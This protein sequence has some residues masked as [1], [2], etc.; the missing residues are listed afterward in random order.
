MYTLNV[1]STRIKFGEYLQDNLKKLYKLVKNKNI[2][3]KFIISSNGNSFPA[4]IIKEKSS[5]DNSII[6]FTIKYFEKNK[7]LYDLMPFKIY[8]FDGQTQEI[9]RNCYI[10]NI[11]NVI[12]SSGNVLISGSNVVNT[13][14]KLCKLLHVERASLH[15]AS[16]VNC[17][18][19]YNLSL[20]P[21]RV[22]DKGPTNTFYEKFNFVPEIHDK[23]FNNDLSLY[24]KQLSKERRKILSITIEDFL[25]EGRKFLSLCEIIDNDLNSM[26]RFNFSKTKTYSDMSDIHIKYNS[27]FNRYILDVKEMFLKNIAIIKNFK[28]KY[29]FP[30]LLKLYKEDCK[31]VKDTILF[32]NLY[33]YQ[34]FDHIEYKNYKLSLHCV[35]IIT[36]F[37][38]MVS[39]FNNLKIELLN[40]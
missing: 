34:Y 33:R 2:R 30:T 21:F 4:I 27:Y 7:D 28:G 12:D 29:L 16:S 9:G 11:H 17:G 6:W 35:K 31:L 26:N 36:K 38:D 22:L 24:Y 40:Y 20:S 3:G 8:F 15:D 25:E 39:D 1:D 5:I 32:E 23:N 18:E 37:Y 13:V 14:L 19:D 10:G